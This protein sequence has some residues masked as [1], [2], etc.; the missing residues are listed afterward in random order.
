MFGLIDEVVEWPPG[1]PGRWDVAPDWH[2]CHPPTEADAIVG[3][4]GLG[5][6]V[7]E[8][9]PGSEGWQHVAPDW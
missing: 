1:P 4:L 6:E 8:W 3:L 2:P 5:D 7:V 9:L